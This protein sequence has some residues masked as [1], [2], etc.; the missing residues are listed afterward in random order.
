MSIVKTF[1]VD[2]PVRYNFRMKYKAYFLTRLV[3][4]RGFAA[5]EIIE[6]ANF[7]EAAL[8]AQALAVQ[9]DRQIMPYQSR[10]RGLR[11]RYEEGEYQIARPWLLVS[12]S[13]YPEPPLNGPLP[14][15]EVEV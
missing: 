7:A 9:Y 11:L 14:D 6:A 13:L 12:I 3:A 1:A 10:G 4:G 15:E 5:T 2:N 8:Q